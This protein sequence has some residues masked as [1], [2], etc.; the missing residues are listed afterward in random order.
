MMKFMTTQRGKLKK[1][2]NYDENQKNRKKCVWRMN[3]HMVRTYFCAA[4]G[5]APENSLY[6]LA[7][8]LTQNVQMDGKIAGNFQQNV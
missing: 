7:Y 2:E 6:L 5:Q 8:L 4:L 1:N 3:D